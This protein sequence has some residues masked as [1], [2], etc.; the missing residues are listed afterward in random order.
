[1][2]VERRVRRRKKVKMLDGIEYV[3]AELVVGAV[4]IFVAVVVF[5][6]WLCA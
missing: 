1:V 4:I 3:E 6:V 2:K 5:I